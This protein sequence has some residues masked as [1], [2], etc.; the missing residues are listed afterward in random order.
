MLKYTTKSVFSWIFSI[1]SPL[2]SF[3]F[4]TGISVFSS[5]TDCAHS[6]RPLQHTQQRATNRLRAPAAASA[7]PLQTRGRTEMALTKGWR[8]QSFLLKKLQS[9]FQ[10]KGLTGNQVHQVLHS[11]PEPSYKLRAAWNTPLSAQAGSPGE[12]FQQSPASAYQHVFVPAS[13]ECAGS[14]GPR[15]LWTSQ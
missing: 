12:S 2:A 13:G 4:S 9:K 6:V 1:Y 8:Q 3:C 15:C 10:S 7:S 11:Q 14:S 5:R